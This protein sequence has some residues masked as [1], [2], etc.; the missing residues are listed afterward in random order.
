MEPYEWV[1]A[2]ES[3]AGVLLST[4]LLTV[5][6]DPQFL[7][8]GEKSD[9]HRRVVLPFRLESRRVRRAYWRPRGIVGVVPR[10]ALAGHSG[11]DRN[12]VNSRV[13]GSGRGAPHTDGG[14]WLGHGIIRQ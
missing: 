12:A 4:A 6:A 2:R 3:D 11:P 14:F 8:T 10:P 1:E 7:A 9:V 13:G 5:R